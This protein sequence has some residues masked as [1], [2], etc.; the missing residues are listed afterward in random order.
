MC[1]AISTCSMTMSK[2][3][4]SMGLF[5]ALCIVP[6]GAIYC[7]WHQPFLCD[8][9]DLAG[10]YNVAATLLQIL[11][12]TC[13]AVYAAALG[14]RI[15]EL[16]HLRLSRIAMLALGVVGFDIAFVLLSLVRL[17]CLKI[18]LPLMFLVGII[19]NREIVKVLKGVVT[20]PKADWRFALLIVPAALHVTMGLLPVT[21]MESHGDITD[22]YWKIPM[23]IAANHGF[24]GLFE[25]TSISASYFTWEALAAGLISF[26]NP[27][28]VKPFGCMI[29]L[30]T[31]VLTADCARAVGAGRYAWLASLGVL[32]CPLFA[33]EI[34]YSYAHPRNFLLHLSMLVCLML[35]HGLRRKQ[36]SYYV[37]AYLISGTLVGTLVGAG[38]I[39]ASIFI[40]VFVLVARAR[41]SM[42]RLHFVALVSG[43]A[44]ALIMPAWNF[45]T[46]GSPIPTCVGLSQRLG[47]RIPDIAFDTYVEARHMIQFNPPVHIGA[48]GYMLF[49]VCL[50]YKYLWVLIVFCIVSVL[51]IRNRGVLFI[52]L[53]A[54]GSVAVYLILLPGS[55]NAETPNA[56]LH[57]VSI[58]LMCSLVPVGVSATTLVVRRCCRWWRIKA[59]L[60]CGVLRMAGAACGVACIGRLLLVCPLLFYFDRA[61]DYFGRQVPLSEMLGIELSCRVK[62]LNERFGR[63]D[64]ILF[65]F[66]EWY[67]SHVRPVLFQPTKHRRGSIVY[68]ERD[69]ALVLKDLSRNQIRWLVFDAIMPWP[70]NEPWQVMI[71]D[72]VT[73]I[74]EPDVLAEHF[75]PVETGV[76]RLHVY[77]IV[78][79]GVKDKDANYERLRKD[80]LFYIVHKVVTDAGED[81]VLIPGN[82]Y[83]LE[84]LKAAYKEAEQRRPGFWKMTR[85]GTG[86]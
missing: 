63:D 70:G 72:I 35:L 10:T 38:V 71:A 9:L 24:A 20:F 68:R 22:S 50:F 33:V 45:V 5:A 43:I 15:A 73:P 3:L 56:R 47:F 4:P 58:C 67:G 79:D 18:N 84:Q 65:F 29:F 53:N 60:V 32:C 49:P 30:V 62:Y 57:C 52:M 66:R 37:P 69:A 13:F 44:V 76:N 19:L 85:M 55:A 1:N 86:M 25:S 31:A 11:L 8:Y 77:R 80:G 12:I 81:T 28:V 17:N 75:V 2:W 27:D 23:A 54:L 7:G 40:G 39:S 21:F 41:P 51:F 64:R 78:F 83:R 74:F 14:M 42:S 46:L 36:E 82:P 34:E 6:C 59:G 26:L 61:C 48:L 16:L